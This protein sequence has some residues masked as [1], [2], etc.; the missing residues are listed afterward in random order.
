MDSEKGSPPP[1][2]GS[3]HLQQADPLLS[4]SENDGAAGCEARRR[5]EKING[6]IKLAVSTVFLVFWI[7]WMCTIIAA[8]FSSKSP[9]DRDNKKFSAFRGKPCSALCHH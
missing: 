6:G 9:V 5:R 7:Y 3:Y 2:E 1:Y 8:I 4:D